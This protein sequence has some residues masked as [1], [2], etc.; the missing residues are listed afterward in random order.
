[1]LRRKLISNSL[2]FQQTTA[3]ATKRINTRKTNAYQPTFSKTLDT[4]KSGGAT[5]KEKRPV[6]V[7]EQHAGKEIELNLS[8]VSDEEFDCDNK[9]DGKLVH[10]NIDDELQLFPR[11]DNT[12]RRQ[13]Y[14]RT[15]Y[16]TGENNE[17]DTTGRKS[18]RLPFAKQTERLGGVPYYTND[19]KQPD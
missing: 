14:T 9:S 6:H 8:I 17:T 19:N 3:A 18:K 1:M 12:Q 5:A 10:T 11:E 13:V 4:R 16:V 2:N 7:A 15:R